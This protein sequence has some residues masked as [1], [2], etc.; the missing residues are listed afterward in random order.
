METPKS[1]GD[2]ATEYGHAALDEDVVG[3]PPVSFLPMSVTLWCCRLRE[4]EYR[5]PLE[6]YD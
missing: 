1:L 5:L 2:V 6:H 4:I 3:V